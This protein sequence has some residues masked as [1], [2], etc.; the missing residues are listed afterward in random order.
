MPNKNAEDYRNKMRN[1][2]EGPFAKSDPEFHELFANFAFDEVVNTVELDDR[3]SFIST[4]AVLLGCGGIDEFRVMTEAALNFGVDPVEIKETVYQATAYLGIG[5]VFPFLKAVNEV[6]A[7][8]GVAVSDEPRTTTTPETRR[9]KGT[10]AQVAIYGDK[11]QD[12]WKSGPEETRHINYW[13]AE[14]CFGDYY[15]RKGL[16]YNMRELVTFC[17][18][19]AQGG[20]E[21]QLTG[22]TRAGM[23]IGND[24]A[25]LIKVL[26]R[27]IPF[28]GY[29]RTLNALRVVNEVAKEFSND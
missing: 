3:I 18:L 4:L 8:N 13:L 26:S 24:K 15:T 28:I 2:K 14:N 19:Y 7:E 25:L 5:R 22:H 6:F 21:G 10:A 29:P 9:E 23:R 11:M 1:S 27:N 12:F 17:Y 16:D 20:C